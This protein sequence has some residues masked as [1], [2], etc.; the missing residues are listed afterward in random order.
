[1]GIPVLLISTDSRLL[2]SISQEPDRY[3]S[4]SAMALP[5]DIESIL[6]HVDE[7]IGRA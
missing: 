5:L 4:H 6:R 7:L 1:L 3:G 2:S